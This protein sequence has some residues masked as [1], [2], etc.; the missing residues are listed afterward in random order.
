MIWKDGFLTGMFTVFLFLRELIVLEYSAR[1][2]TPASLP[3][4]R[5]LMGQSKADL[6]GHSDGRVLFISATF[7]HPNDRGSFQEGLGRAGVVSI[8]VCCQCIIYMQQRRIITKTFNSGK[9]PSTLRSQSRKGDS[10]P[11]VSQ[12]LKRPAVSSVFRGIKTMESIL[13]AGKVKNSSVC[14]QVAL[15]SHR[16]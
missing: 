5:W 3:A 7:Y 13:G 6:S 9:P 4:L 8:H 16:H 11:F 15:C 12:T 14:T 2:R 1:N 10:E